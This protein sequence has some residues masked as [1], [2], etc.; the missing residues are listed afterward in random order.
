MSVL[1]GCFLTNA[2]SFETSLPL[3]TV[4]L[5]N[6]PAPHFPANGSLILLPNGK[7]QEYEGQENEDSKSL[8]DQRGAC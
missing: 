1:S 7:R 4:V 2:M 8:V 3:L 6:L 5:S